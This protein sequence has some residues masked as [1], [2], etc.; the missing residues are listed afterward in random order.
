M[1]HLTPCVW[2]A[3]AACDVLTPCQ[4]PLE[5]WCIHSEDDEGPVFPEGV[6]AADVECAPP[7]IAS[8][9]AAC[10]DHEEHV[11]S[12]GFASTSHYFLDGEHVAT[13]YGTDVNTYCGGFDFWYGKPVECPIQ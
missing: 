11:F 4:E 10:G 5:L 12:L 13:R 8:Q 3:A 9:P 7:D 1:R 6:D 2:L